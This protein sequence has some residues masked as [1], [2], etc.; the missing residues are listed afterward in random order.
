MFT[1]G[2][3]ST[4]VSSPSKRRQ[5]GIPPA[6]AAAHAAATE[7]ASTALAPSRLRSGEPSASRSAASRVSW[8][9]ASTPIARAA[10]SPR[11]LATAPR[12]PRPPYLVPP[13]RSSTASWAPVEAPD[14]TTTAPR[15][16]ER[17]DTSQATVGSPRESS[18]SHAKTSVIAAAFND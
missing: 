4:G 10:S 18:A 5:R 11:T 9:S 3:G 1:I 15:A 7:T 17:R 6:F 16:P 13:S 8:S 2:I 14:G 12:T